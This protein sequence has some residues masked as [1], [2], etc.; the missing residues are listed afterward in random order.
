MAM[1]RPSGRAQTIAEKVIPGLRRGKKSRTRTK[2]KT[3]GFM[4]EVE[5]RQTH[6]IEN[7]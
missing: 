7:K 2:G 6:A 4:S 3:K 1:P 5:K